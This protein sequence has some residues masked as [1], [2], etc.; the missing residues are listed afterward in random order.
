MSL[1]KAPRMAD[2]SR[3]Q[4]ARLE[5][6]AVRVDPNAYVECAFERNVEVRVAIGRM[7]SG[8][9]LDICNHPRSLEAAEAAL[10]VLAGE[11]SPREEAARDVLRS[12]A[13]YAGNGGY[14]AP[15]PIDLAQ[16]DAKIRDGMDRTA[17]AF[18]R[19]ALAERDLTELR[20]RLGKLVERWIIETDDE[21][22]EDSPITGHALDELRAAME[23]PNG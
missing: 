19:G 18:V 15:D 7:G 10:C 5:E 4:R 23:A 20:E 1:G 12:L 11:P 14:N 8:G 9:L 22:F 16:F 2:A 13:S 21:H 17:D 6:L 3:E